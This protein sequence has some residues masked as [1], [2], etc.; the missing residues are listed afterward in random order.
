VKLKAAIKDPNQSLYLPVK[1]KKLEF[2][3]IKWPLTKFIKSKKSTFK[4]VLI[5]KNLEQSIQTLY[6]KE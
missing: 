5:I 2:K 6:N 4:I 1:S 3:G